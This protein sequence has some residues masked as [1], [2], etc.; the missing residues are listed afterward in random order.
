MALDLC[1]GKRL[2]GM[3]SGLHELRASSVM[4]TV[5]E[6]GLVDS[7]FSRVNFFASGLPASLGSG[8][9]GSSHSSQSSS[10]RRVNFGGSFSLSFSGVWRLARYSS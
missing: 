4:A 6:N 3:L 7:R 1:P 10:Q 9:V 8:S 2:W 5:R